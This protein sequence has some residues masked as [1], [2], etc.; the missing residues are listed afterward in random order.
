MIDEALIESLEP[1]I[2]ELADAFDRA[3]EQYL[4]FQSN[5]GAC[6]DSYFR[7]H[8]FRYLVKGHLQNKGFELL[9][10]PNTGIEVVLPN[11]RIKVLR[12]TPAGTPPKPGSMTQLGYRMTSR[13]VPSDGSPAASFW[14]VF[15]PD[16][17]KDGLPHLIADWYLSGDGAVIHLSEIDP[18]DIEGTTVLWRALVS[19][20]DDEHLEFIPT[21]D[22]FSIFDDESDDEESIERIAL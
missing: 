10:V 9:H 4:E 11:A 14:N 19:R 3:Y 22:P 12:S 21:D 20:P 7:S 17:Q 5:N 18:C 1:F 15:L 2:A 13:L 16:N 6:R 8:L